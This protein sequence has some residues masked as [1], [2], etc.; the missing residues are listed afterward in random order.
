MARLVQRHALVHIPQQLLGATRR[1]SAE[2]RLHHTPL[3]EGVEGAQRHAVEVAP[4]AARH[5]AGRPAR[6]DE[7]VPLRREHLRAMLLDLVACP[8]S[9]VDAVDQ[10]QRSPRHERLP[11]CEV[12]VGAATVRRVQVRVRPVPSG[13]EGLA[14]AVVQEQLLQPLHLDQDRDQRTAA[15]AALGLGA[16][17]RMHHE[18]RHQACLARGWARRQKDGTGR[19]SVAV[20]PPR[21]HA[22]QPVGQP[23]HVAHLRQRRSGRRR[24]RRRITTSIDTADAVAC[25]TADDA[26]AVARHRHLVKRHHLNRHALLKHVEPPAGESVGDAGML[27]A[28]VASIL[29][30]HYLQRCRRHQP[31]RVVPWVEHHRT[32][33]RRRQPRRRR[34]LL[35]RR[36]EAQNVLARRPRRHRR[37]NGA[38]APSAPIPHH[39]QL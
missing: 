34:M 5:H 9:L 22:M 38:V 7:H 27:R 8:A 17:Q 31:W 20:A 3:L 36:K 18:L 10:D 14:V 37:H 21:I 33:L 39:E 35:S 19:R 16:L 29:A 28:H 6:D 25:P 1:A 13:S 23:T 26:A 12:E 30:Q 2:P 24:R 15:A 32:L 4:V 11:K